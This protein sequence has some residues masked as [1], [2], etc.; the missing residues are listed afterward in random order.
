MPNI[1]S[2]KKRMRT[3]AQNQARNRA[4]RSRIVTTR[5]SLYDAIATGDPVVCKEALSSFCSIL[6]KAVKCG[7]IK[8]NAAARRK[9]RAA[10]RIRRKP[11][12]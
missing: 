2:A 10:A 8:S 4:A 12:A 6:D 5:R 1:K 11:A 7:A 9:S 3:S